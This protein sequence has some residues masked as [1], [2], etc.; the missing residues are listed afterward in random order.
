MRKIAG[1]GTAHNKEKTKI[2]GNVMRVEQTL[3]EC[4]LTRLGCIYFM[5]SA[6]VLQLSSIAILAV[7]LRLKK[8]E[9]CFS[10]V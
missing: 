10:R 3:D 1:H 9:G 7:E 6:N 8:A 5:S 2:I 4:L